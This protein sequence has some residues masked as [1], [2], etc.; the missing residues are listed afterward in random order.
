MPNGG[1]AS[2]SGETSNRPS[3][4]ISTFMTVHSLFDAEYFE[5][6]VRIQEPDV[7]EW[8]ASAGDDLLE[9]GEVPILA[10]N[11]LV[12]GE[13]TA[14][15]E[16]GVLRVEPVVSLLKPALQSQ[17]MVAFDDNRLTP[18]TACVCDEARD[19]L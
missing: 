14:Q 10:L 3:R 18:V 16:Q 15:E 6:L 4:T 1:F 5:A 2:H 9:D 13:L 17:V 19:L 12:H 7:V 11:G 8:E